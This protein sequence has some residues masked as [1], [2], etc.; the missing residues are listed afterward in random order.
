[1]WSVN[2]MYSNQYQNGLHVKIWRQPHAINGFFWN[3]HWLDKTSHNLWRDLIHI[4]NC[5]QRRW[6]VHI[7]SPL[8]QRWRRIIQQILA[9]FGNRERWIIINYKSL[10]VIF[11][12]Y[13]Y[14][15]YIYIYICIYI[16]IYIIDFWWFEGHETPNEYPGI[17]LNNLMERLK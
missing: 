5:N 8:D 7:L 15:I 17:T 13:A 14:N 12:K 11:K 2:S 4:L 16:Y 6:N 1:M 10:S 3:I 9:S